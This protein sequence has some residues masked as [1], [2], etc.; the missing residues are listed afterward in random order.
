MVAL[1]ISA[2]VLQHVLINFILGVLAAKS[3]VVRSDLNCKHLSIVWSIARIS[4]V[5]MQH[6]L[7]SELQELSKAFV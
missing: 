1:S 2:D 6:V 7:V 5:H 4:S 3:A